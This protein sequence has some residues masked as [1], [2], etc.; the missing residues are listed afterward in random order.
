MEHGPALQALERPFVTYLRGNLPAG[1]A[2]HFHGLREA[3][4]QLKG[5]GILDRLDRESPADMGAE[6]LTWT[7]REIENYLCN[8]ETLCA[9][10]KTTAQEQAPGELW[11]GAEAERR[12]KAMMDAIEE[13]ETALRTLGKGSPWSA[14]IKAS[15]EFLTPLFQKYYAKLGLPNLMAKKNFHEL[16]RFVP[17]EKIDPEVAEKLDA[18]ARVAQSACPRS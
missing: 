9:F 1:V 11:G 13:V 17:R 3:L 2:R 16:A 4:P 6:I 10:A 15:D 18:I 5:I 8:R 12:H 14:D 7:R